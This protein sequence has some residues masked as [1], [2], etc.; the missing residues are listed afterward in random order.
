MKSQC[1]IGRRLQAGLRSFVCHTR[2]DE[3]RKRRL[4]ISGSPELWP[5]CRTSPQGL[6]INKLTYPQYA[7][8]LAWDEYTDCGMVME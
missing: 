3:A 4:L 6:A 1:L 7:G 5:S 8:D 2:F